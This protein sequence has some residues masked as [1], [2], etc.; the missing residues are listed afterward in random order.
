MLTRLLSVSISTKLIVLSVLLLITA[1]GLTA[2]TLIE[3]H[4]DAIKSDLVDKSKVFTA[5]A[6]EVKNHVSDLHKAGSFD[7]EKLTE[8]VQV[9][10]AQ[11]R[12]YAE[13]NFFRTVPVVAGWQAAE[14]A[15]KR[16]NVQFRVLAFQARNKDNEPQAGSFEND[17]LQNLTKQ[18]SS[19]GGEEIWG[20]D[21]K[22]H[23]LVYMRAIKLDASCMMCHG[24]PATS[25]S[26]DGKDM[27]GFAMENWKPGDRS[28]PA[29]AGRSPPPAS[30]SPRARASR[31]R[32]SS[33]S[34]RPSKRCPR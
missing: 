5:L 13:T 34:A 29:R 30:R 31:P 10:K 25:P 12:A 32:A 21:H 23:A 27:L 9:A 28:T 2:F 26:G 19:G 17:L 6:D 33:R 16:E 4:R 7:K 8:E 15:A 18:I 20:E 11:G 1:T 14:E 3:N 22:S 24:D